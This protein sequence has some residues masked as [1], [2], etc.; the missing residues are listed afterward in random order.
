MASSASRAASVEELK[1]RGNDRFAKGDLCG[2]AKLYKHALQQGGAVHLLQSNLSA[3][4]LQGRMLAAALE[5]ADA[6]IAAE[7]SWPKAHFRRGSV[8]AALELW[9]E[10]ALSYQRALAYEPQNATLHKALQAA[11][12][13]L[14]SP[15]AL[16]AGSVFSWGR[17]EFGAL[18]HGDV[19]E[20]VAFNPNP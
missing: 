1:A 4:Y 6:A 2:A 19:K 18:G 17:G 20:T 14:A 10:A 11:Q 8:L 16:G 13:Q 5:A 3:V 9:R 7:P 15:H 12:A